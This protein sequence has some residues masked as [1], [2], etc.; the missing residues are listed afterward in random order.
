MRKLILF[1]LVIMAMI[2]S[3]NAQEAKNEA[4]VNLLGLII[5]LPD[6]SYERLLNDKMGSGLS[7]AA[8]LKNG[9]YYHNQYRYVVI[10][11][12]RYYF[13]SKYASG[14]FLEAHASV[15]SA[16]K[17]LKT[18]F[19]A[20]EEFEQYYGLGA[21][22]GIKLF[23]KKGFSAEVYAGLGQQLNVDKEKLQDKSLQLYPRIG[24][25]IGKRF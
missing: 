25:S 24:I 22:M 17:D 9:K 5:G 21:A 20:E 12:Y 7:V 1:S 8:G 11:H 2:I 23:N 19:E 6:L 15:I 4:K 16:K 18:E 13:G 3:A 14:F 10:P